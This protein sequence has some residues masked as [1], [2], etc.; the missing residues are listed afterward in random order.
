MTP[1]VNRLS[2]PSEVNSFLRSELLQAGIGVTDSI[3][4]LCCHVQTSISGTLGPWSFLRE[5]MY[6][7]AEGPG[8]PM[9]AAMELQADYAS[10]V[11]VGGVAG[12]TDPRKY[13]SGFSIPVYHIDTHEGLLAFANKLKEIM[14]QAKDLVI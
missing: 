13:F 14:I 8:M 5:E 1:F 10:T 3:V 11:R 7:V 9:Q 6:W 12:G 4:N 2:D